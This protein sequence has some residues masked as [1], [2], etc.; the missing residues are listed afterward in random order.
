MHSA[1]KECSAGAVQC[2]AGMCHCGHVLCPQPVTHFRECALCALLCAHC[3]RHPVMQCLACPRLLL[4]MVCS[5]EQWCPVGVGVLWAL[6][7]LS[8]KSQGGLYW[9]SNNWHSALVSN[10][11][12]FLCN[13]HMPLAPAMP[14]RALR[15]ATP[16]AERRCKYKHNATIF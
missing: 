15:V 9:R 4:G 11:A 3:A 7:S 13:R 12:Y 16:W 2:S 6:L 8:V 5:A 10:D 14:M 1:R